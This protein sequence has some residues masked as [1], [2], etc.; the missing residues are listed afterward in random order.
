MGGF[1]QAA[2]MPEPLCSV[3][4]C[5]QIFQQQQFNQNYSMFLRWSIREVHVDRGKQAPKIKVRHCSI[6]CS[7]RHQSRCFIRHHI[8][9]GFD[10]KRVYFI[11][12]IPNWYLSLVWCPNWETIFNNLWGFHTLILDVKM[13][14][15]A[16]SSH[17]TLLNVLSERQFYKRLFHFFL[18]TLFPVGGGLGQHQMNVAYGMSGKS[19]L[20]CSLFLQNHFS[21]SACWKARSPPSEMMN[22]AGK[23]RS[24]F[25]RLQ[26]RTSQMCWRK[27]WQCPTFPW[28][29][30]G[31]PQLCK[32]CQN[33]FFRLAKQAAA[34]A[35]AAERKLS[36]PSSQAVFQLSQ[37]PPALCHL[38]PASFRQ[39]FTAGCSVQGMLKSFLR[40]KGI[41]TKRQI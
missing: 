30:P 25:E 3:A 18:I 15:K 4:L 41:S 17:T 21:N 10:Y 1:S 31:D 7:V 37:L 33:F 5:T 23:F 6:T 27:P 8:C 20:N 9:N 13:S 39:K 16:H 11:K 12:W 26:P 36:L 38:V 19:K 29:H 34:A 22:C 35:S 14:F 28:N 40:S 24:A 2:H 32:L